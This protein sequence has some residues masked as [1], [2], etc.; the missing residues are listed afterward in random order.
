V[1]GGRCPPSALP[2]TVASFHPVVSALSTTGALRKDQEALA[3]AVTQVSR[4]VED[5]GMRLVLLGADS[6]EA[7]RSLSSGE[8]EQVLDT[9]VLEDPRLLER[10]PDHLVTLPLQVWL[11]PAR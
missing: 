8:V 6:D 4:A 9:T 10:R 2:R 1:S 11:A 7:V 5:R 3:D